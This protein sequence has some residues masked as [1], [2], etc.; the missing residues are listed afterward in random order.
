MDVRVRLS[1]W[2]ELP[3]G[4]PCPAAASILWPLH[5]ERAPWL[6]KHPSSTC[7]RPKSSNSAP[8]PTPTPRPRPWPS[9]PDSSSCAPPGQSPASRATT[10]PPRDSAAPPTPFPS[11][12]AASNATA[13]TAWTTSPAVADR[14]PFPPQDRHKVLVLATTK[15]ADVGVPASHW[16]LDDLAFYIPRAAH[17]RDMARSTVQ[18][19]LAEADLKPHK[20]RYWLHSNDPDFEAKAL[21]ICR[22]YLDAPRLYQQ[23]ELVVC[24]DEKTSIQAL[25]RLHPTK[26]VRPGT[27][28][29]QEFEYIRRGTR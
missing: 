25:E 6:V 1:A 14:P 29:L 12:V 15:P 17:Y 19:I 10:T 2:T 5:T 8:W 11:G 4:L 13:W 21:D 26:P 23:G 16:S 18:R 3:L 20:S 24:V 22:L 7:P 9:A 28:A 27:P